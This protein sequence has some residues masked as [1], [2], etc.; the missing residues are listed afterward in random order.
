VEDRLRR[1]FAVDVRAKIHPP[2]RFILVL[3][4]HCYQLPPLAPSILHGGSAAESLLE[5]ARG[6]ISPA[7]LD[8]KYVYR[9]S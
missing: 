2:G 9:M 4:R 1:F 6:S 5:R 8:N 3:I 7:V